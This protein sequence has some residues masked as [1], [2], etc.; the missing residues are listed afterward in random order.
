MLNQLGFGWL[1]SEL[2]DPADQLGWIL[3]QCFLIPTIEKQCQCGSTASSLAVCPFSAMTGET[4]S[5]DILSCSVFRSSTHWATFM[6]VGPKVTGCVFLIDAGDPTG[7]HWS[8][9]I[10]EKLWSGLCW[11]HWRQQICFGQPRHHGCC[12]YWRHEAGSSWDQ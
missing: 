5:L 3:L 2:E 11:T 1:T 8:F 10:M 12:P 4:A 6:D 9:L 7:N